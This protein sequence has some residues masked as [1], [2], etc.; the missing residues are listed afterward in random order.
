MSNRYRKTKKC[1]KCGNVRA[2]VAKKLCCS[3][4]N[5]SHFGL[6][7][8]RERLREWT[9]K[10]RAR[11]RAY[12]KEYGRKNRAYFTKYHRE[13]A[14]KNKAHLKAYRQ[15][16]QKPTYFTKKWQKPKVEVKE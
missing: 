6:A 3:C 9:K 10:N 4:Y 12:R 13:W 7:Y 16:W 15:K 5:K 8:F 14:R 11:I 2:I 1:K